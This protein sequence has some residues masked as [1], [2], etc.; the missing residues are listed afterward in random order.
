MKDKTAFS[1]Y[2]NV[3][4]VKELLLPLPLALAFLKNKILSSKSKKGNHDQELSE[5]SIYFYYETLNF[6]TLLHL[7]F[8]NL[9]SDLNLFSKNANKLYKS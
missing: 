1:S 4:L 2:N 5:H 8:K 6:D 9:L 7:L 3:V